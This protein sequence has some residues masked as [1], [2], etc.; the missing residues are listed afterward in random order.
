MNRIQCFL[1]VALL[2]ISWMKKNLLFFSFSMLFL[3]LLLRFVYHVNI[4]S[5]FNGWF[6]SPLRIIF[7]AA[8]SHHSLAN[9]MFQWLENKSNERKNHFG[10]LSNFW[11]EFYKNEKRR[12]RKKQM[13]WTPSV[14]HY[15]FYNKCGRQMNLI[16][17][18]LHFRNRNTHQNN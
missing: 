17:R 5:K 7:S 14:A 2:T 4:K 9:T 1:M 18:K 10:S 6:K 13:V 11:N 3:L 12:R 15:L 8:F 16:T